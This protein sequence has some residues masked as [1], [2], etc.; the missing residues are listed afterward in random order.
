LVLFQGSDQ[1]DTGMKSEINEISKTLSEVGLEEYDVNGD[2]NCLFRAICHQL[3]GSDRNHLQLRSQAVDYIQNKKDEFT[4][5]LEEQIDKYV[6]RMSKSGVYGGNLEL[7]AISKLMNLNIVIYQAQSAPLLIQSPQSSDKTIYLIYYSYEHYASTIKTCSFKP[8]ALMEAKANKKTQEMTNQ[9]IRISGYHNIKKIH[10]LLDK[11]NG[12]FGLV[13]DD[14]YELA[15]ND[16]QDSDQEDQEEVKKVNEDSI[17]KARDRKK[18]SKS[19]RKQA[20]LEKKRN[21]K[22][23]TDTANTQEIEEGLSGIHI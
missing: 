20:A 6:I 5:F 19:K 21:I 23:G 11:H 18:I 3:Y 15:V 9:I 17:I 13:L 2:G 22:L 16:Q 8:P 14:I 4:P 12:K 7:V 1:C 10:E